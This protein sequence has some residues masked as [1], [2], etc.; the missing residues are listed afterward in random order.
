[1]SARANKEKK[2]F[3]FFWIFYL[4]LL[5][6]IAV[7]LLKIRAQVTAIMQD[8]EQMVPENYIMRM[9]KDAAPGDGALGD[10]MEAN[11]F[12]QQYGDGAARS[13]RFYETL[14]SADIA[15][16]AEQGTSASSHPVY[17]VT[18]DDKPFLRLVLSEGE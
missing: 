15:F 3:D 1:M 12:S 9:I 8:Y 13:A 14:K 11:V 6:V 16:E 17:R 7:A 10:F 18:A 2:K 5:A 4:I